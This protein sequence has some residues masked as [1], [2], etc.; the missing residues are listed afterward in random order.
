MTASSAIGSPRPPG[1]RRGADPRVADVIKAYWDYASVYYGNEQGRS[2]LG[3][4]KLAL[5]TL[6]RL[7]GQTLA[8]EF[9]PLALQ[10]VRNRMVADGWSRTYVNAQVGRLK[11]AFRWAA[12]KSSS[13]RQCSTDSSQSPACDRVNA[14]R[15]RPSR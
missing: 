9:G 15:G 2:E 11:R 3:S 8:R 12:S 7:Y 1:P 4:I 10:T 5:A 14:R 6:R 13:R